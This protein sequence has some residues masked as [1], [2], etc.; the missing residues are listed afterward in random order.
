[1]YAVDQDINCIVAVLCLIETSDKNYDNIIPRQ[2]TLYNSGVVGKIINMT[3]ISD[4]HIFHYLP[5]ATDNAPEGDFIYGTDKDQKMILEKIDDR[6]GKLIDSLYNSTA[7]GGYLTIT[8]YMKCTGSKMR[9]SEK[10]VITLFTKHGFIFEKSFTSTFKEPIHYIIF[11][12][13]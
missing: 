12:K 13:V 7:K 2:N 10:S 9:M 8:E 5:D 11:K 3:F 6:W 4:V 1:M